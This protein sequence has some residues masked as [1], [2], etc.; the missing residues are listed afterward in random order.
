[1]RNFNHKIDLGNGKWAYVQE[2]HLIPHA[3]RMTNLII[4]RAR[5]PKFYFH[6]HSG[7]HVMASKLH[8][9]NSFF[10]HIDLE[11]FFYHVSKN[12]IV[13]SMKKV[14]FGFREAEGFAVVSTVRSEKG[15]TLPFGFVQSPALA[16][17][18]LDQSQLGKTLREIAPNVQTTLYGDDILLSSK[19]EK[20][21]R[22]ASDNVL[23]ACQKA[24]FPT[25]QE[26]TK[27]VQT[28]ITAFNINISRNCLEITEERMND[29]YVN[30]RHLGN[31]PTTQGILGYVS[32]VNQR[33]AEDLQKLL[34]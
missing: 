13:R 10:S 28:K 27:V 6:F 7:G 16:A 14:G 26:K 9:E 24:N 3:R 33:Q 34:L 8:S 23:L 17:L 12:K 20:T 21:L 32:R 4:E 18:V 1:M 30:I 11:R 22:E 19:N 25:N 15:F 2:K 31:C 5:F 29:F